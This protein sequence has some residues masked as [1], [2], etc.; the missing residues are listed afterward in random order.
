MK[1]REYM[2]QIA[3]SG[4]PA[5]NE[6]RISA[7]KNYESTIS[8]FQNISNNFTFEGQQL[9]HSRTIV[10]RPVLDCFIKQ[11]FLTASRR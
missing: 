5:G 10:L 2:F 8:V 7:P 6:E 11:L 1:V 4:T 9:R 3:H